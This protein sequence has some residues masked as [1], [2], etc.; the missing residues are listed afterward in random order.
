[1]NMR[2]IITAS[3]L[4]LVALTGSS[5]AAPLGTVNGNYAEPTDPFQFCFGPG[6]LCP[7]LLGGQALFGPLT[8]GGYT[9][10]ITSSRA[11]SEIEISEPAEL[12]YDFFGDDGTYQGGDENPTVIVDGIIDVP[13]SN[14][15]IYKFVLP[16]G[17][18]PEF[19]PDGHIE[20]TEDT[21]FG[22]TGVELPIFDSGTF[23]IALFAGVPEP[24]TWVE[25]IVGLA[26]VG[27]AIRRRPV[28]VVTT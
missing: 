5:T 7:T 13:T 1:M 18:A 12:N 3:V 19:W 8:P 16:P 9:L 28:N 22:Q 24:T 27:W 17:P 25:A 20:T 11:L 10:H 21:I 14:D 26:L 23:T 4:V 6:S 15:F 2:G